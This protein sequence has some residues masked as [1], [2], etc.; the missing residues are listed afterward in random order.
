MRHGLGKGFAKDRHGLDLSSGWA[1]V[2]LGWRGTAGA[3][4]PPGG[5]PVRACRPGEP[6]SR[7]SGRRPAS[8][9]NEASG[10][11]RPSRTPCLAT[12]LGLPPPAGSPAAAL[13]PVNSVCAMKTIRR[14][15]LPLIAFLGALC[16]LPHAAP[17]ADQSA[18]LV[19]GTSR[20]D[21]PSLLNVSFPPMSGLN[22]ESANSL[23]ISMDVI[24]D[25]RSTR[26]LAQA[27]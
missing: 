13:L 3:S 19:S 24:A 5:W 21:E 16:S 7:P 26:A 14:W 11:L 18:T 2:G 8:A 23:A 6:R 15:V 12:A 9:W 4:A 27:H 10:T 17:G 20:A 1:P 22:R 25:H